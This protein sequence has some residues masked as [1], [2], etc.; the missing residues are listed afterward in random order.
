[1]LPG[2]WRSSRASDRPRPHSR[3]EKCRTKAEG[4]H[5]HSPFQGAPKPPGRSGRDRYSPGQCRRMERMDRCAAAARCQHEPDQRY[6][7]QHERRQR[8][9]EPVD[10]LLDARGIRVERIGMAGITMLISVLSLIASLEPS[11]VAHSA[12][13]FGASPLSL[14]ADGAP[15]A[16]ANRFLAARSRPRGRASDEDRQRHIIDP[17]S[18]NRAIRGRRGGYASARNLCRRESRSLPVRG[19]AKSYIEKRPVGAGSPPSAS[20]NQGVSGSWGRPTSEW[21][22]P[23]RAQAGIGS[24]QPPD[25]CGISTCPPNP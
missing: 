17:R 18:I 15:A 20:A 16:P 4:G 7:H 24:A 23:D 11:T 6:R 19:R 10:D 1:M 2:R 25:H 14:A 13:R 12:S 9:L 21:K 22:A 8:Q 5:P 3:R